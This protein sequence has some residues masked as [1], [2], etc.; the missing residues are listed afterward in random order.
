MKCRLPFGTGSGPNFIFHVNI[1]QEFLLSQNSRGLSKLQPSRQQQNEDT[2]CSYM[3]PF[4]ASFSF[5]RYD[6]TV[7]NTFKLIRFCVGHGRSLE[8]E[9]THVNY[10]SSAMQPIQL[11]V[12]LRIFMEIFLITRAFSS[13]ISRA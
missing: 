13:V 9:T 8:T 2:L 4:G 1:S 11:R 3:F 6:F 5:C 7:K 12:L 10:F